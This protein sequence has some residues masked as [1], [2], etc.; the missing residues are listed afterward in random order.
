[1]KKKEILFVTSQSEKFEDGLSYAVYLAGTLAMNLNVLIMGSRANRFDNAMTSVTFAEAGEHEKAMEY[2][3]W[4]DPGFLHIRIKDLCD[5]SGVK[6]SIHTRLSA[7]PSVIKDF[8]GRL[9]L[10]M[11]L[12]SP[13]LSGD[14]ELLKSLLKESTHR[15]VTLGQDK[16]MAAGYAK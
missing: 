8:L 14:G 1:M 9:S 15:V 6:S 3:N 10:D 5:R 11:V 12:L 16:N 4:P 7:N 2:I 13:S